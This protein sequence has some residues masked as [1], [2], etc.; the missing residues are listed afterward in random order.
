MRSGLIAASGLALGCCFASVAHSDLPSKIASASGDCSDGTA[1]YQT[2]AQQVAHP[3]TIVRYSMGSGSGQIDNSAFFGPDV[4]WADGGPLGV[5]DA[6]TGTVSCDPGPDIPFTVDVFATPKLPTSFD[7]ATTPGSCPASPTP[8]CGSILSFIVP[9]SGRIQARVNVSQGAIAVDDPYDSYSKVLRTA[10]TGTL[11]FRATEG[12]QALR[13]QADD[14]PQAIWSLRVT[15]VVTPSGTLVNCLE[16]LP[17]TG[18]VALV[19]RMRPKT[20]NFEGEPRVGANDVAIRHARWTTWTAT[21]AR[22]RGVELPYHSG[23]AEKAHSVRLRLSRPRPGC[24][25]RR[26]FTRLLVLNGVKSFRLR[27]APGCR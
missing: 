4:A 10:S 23:G 8:Q 22:G 20:C 7:G 15:A 5:G 18:R 26:H 13:V 12:L 27:L 6:M 3:T 9:R 24:K 1:K 14:G 19:G 2:D 16:Y 17:A 11:D 25:G 21:S